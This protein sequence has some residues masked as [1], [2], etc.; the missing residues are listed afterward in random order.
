MLSHLRA[1][2]K[3]LWRRTDWERDLNDELRS[4]LEHRVDDLVSKGMSIPK[5]KRQARIELGSSESYKEQCRASHGLRWPDELH[6]D[7]RYAVRAMIKSP[8]F[9]LVAVA[10]LA[11]GLGAN[12]V[13]FGVLSALLLRPLPVEDPE[14]LFAI[15]NRRNS[16][17]S[18]PNY[19]DIRDRNS[20][21]REIAAARITHMG[22]GEPDGAELVW[23]YLVSGSYFQM[24]GIQPALG[25][26]FGPD[27]DRVV[28][29]SPYAVLSHRTW[30]RRFQS[31]R[32]IVGKTIRL[33]THP[34][35]VLGVA[36]EDFHGTELL[37]WPEIWVP[38]TMQPQI[39]GRSWLED[40]SSTNS[41]ILGRLKP[42]VTP[43]QAVADLR[44][45]A[46]SI[47]REHPAGNARLSY[48]LAAP[49]LFGD[50]LRTPIRA[51][52][53]GVMALAGLV[54]LAAC[55]NLASLLTAR[56][57]DRLREIAIR[58]AVGAGRGRIIRQ[59][60]TEAM[61]LA[62]A[63]G[64]A[65]WGV[66]VA[67]LQALSHLRAPLG[68]PIGFD[69]QA[70]AGVF[71]F[72]AVVSLATGVVVGLAP[73][74]GALRT[75]P[76]DA[77]SAGSGGSDGRRG[78]PRRD[79]L[80]VLQ[81][82]ACCVLVTASLVAFEGL[83][84][85][86]SADIGFEPDGV[87]AVNFDLALAGYEPEAGRAFRERALEAAASLPGVSQAAYSSRTPLSPDQST[88]TVLPVD[89]VD[90]KR[91]QG[92]GASVYEISPGALSILGIPLH[93]GRDFT[94]H[95]DRGTPRIAIV[96]QTFVERVLREGEPLGQRF[97]HGRGGTL[98]EVV[99]VV[100]AGKH[101]FLAEDPQPA[102]FWP[103]GQRYNSS[104][105]ILA[106]SNRPEAEVARELQAMLVGTDEN[107]PL[108]GVGGLRQML[109]FQLIPAHVASVALGAFGVLAVMLVVT[110][111][112]GLASYA[113]SRRM[114]EIGIRTAIGA[115]RTQVLKCVLGRT[116]LLVVAGTATG[117]ALGLIASEALG[118]V[119]Y[120]A[121][122]GDPFLIASAALTVAVTALLS[123]AAPAWRALT[124]HPSLVLRE[125]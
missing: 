99:G 19:R 30:E 37:Y 100:G 87:A 121:S 13:V 71:A 6:Q 62:L 34:Y 61:V 17:H 73:V 112:Y 15:Q 82:A 51:F 60:L 53:G 2:W 42:G 115:S 33:N 93:S 23:G 69:V 90:L 109:A 11:L 24:L 105:V 43:E 75:Q 54:L 125:D 27:E 14:R 3:G 94:V 31:D 67:L 10:S 22:L 78:W 40:R 86:V 76:R 113:V 70:D 21:F 89:T 20:T 63:G 107:L 9:T 35:T 116:A 49:G 38:I 8:A 72:I 7:L 18:I 36:P 122:A 12:T 102:V 98:V 32:E 28:G 41:A 79:L 55:A 26:F 80:L 120:H 56:T 97:Y 29:A 108:F 47:K 104:T 88:T 44:V 118:R 117:L 106:K 45:I 123:A 4:H 124:V 68:L 77:L 48:N 110:G 52:A 96:N 5:A 57:S 85:A 92:H 65:G 114:R 81:V 101:G 74:R 83:S 91:G 64:L 39:E 50:A 16:T 58:T 1:L 111:I 119:V 84:S 103:A 46:E 66:G 95:D 59:L 25:R